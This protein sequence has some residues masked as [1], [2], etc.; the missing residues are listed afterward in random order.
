MTRLRCAHE[1]DIARAARTRFWSEALK[2][3]AENCTICSEVRAVTE[4]LT[5]DRARMGA[6]AQPPDAGLVWMEAR[7]RA[8]LSLRHRAELC[9][10]ALRALTG[11]YAVASCAWLLLHYTGS[12]SGLW[13][14]SFHADFAS[15][16]TG[17]A[18]GLAAAGVVLA[19]ICVSMGWW[20]LLREARQPLEASP[21]R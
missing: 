17:P 1:T 5:G 6:S 2:G 8:R 12:T 20:Y 18:E 4:A 10:R 7:R 21:S 14:P 15:L 19:A 13:K 9:F 3:H 16:L 11:V